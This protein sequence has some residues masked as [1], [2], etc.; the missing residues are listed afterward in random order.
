MSVKPLL[1][2]VTQQETV[3]LFDIL[4]LKLLGIISDALPSTH[5]T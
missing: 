2:F 3:S 1:K 4:M 5:L